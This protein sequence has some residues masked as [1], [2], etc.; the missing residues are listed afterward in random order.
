MSSRSLAEYRAMFSLTEDDLNSRIL[1]CPGGAASFTG[2]VNGLGGKATA[3]DSAYFDTTP[4]DL[5]AIAINEAERGNA[6]VH[7]HRHN[8]TWTYFADPDHHERIREDAAG[9]FATDINDHPEQYVPGRLPS[10][11][12]GDDSFDL[13]LSSHLLFSYSDVLDH[14]FHIDSITELARVSR[15][16]VRIFPLV[17]VGEPTPYPHLGELLEN[18][19]DRGIDC[20]IV[21]VD[22][23]FQRSADEML[24]CSRGPTRS[25]DRSENAP[26]ER[27]H[28]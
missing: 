28:R 18:L 16:E 26:E 13:V 24:V 15:G 20:R 1:D 9:R 2:E 3:C 22:Y 12:F 11:P 7:T 8:Y 5:A 19:A 17:A 23:E 10:L 4:A 21:K 25:V 27:I 6:F 14:Q